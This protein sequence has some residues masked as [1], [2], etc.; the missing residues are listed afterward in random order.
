[1]EKAVKAAEKE[2]HM[3]AE[4]LRLL[5]VTPKKIEAV[6]AG[7]PAPVAKTAAEEEPPTT[8]PADTSGAAAVD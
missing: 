3:S 6:K 2:E 4:I 7:R 1:M 8:R 5:A